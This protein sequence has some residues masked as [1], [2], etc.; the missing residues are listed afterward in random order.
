MNIHYNEIISDPLPLKVIN[1][2]NRQSNR[3]GRYKKGLAP[4]RK[5]RKRLHKKLAKRGFSASEAFVIWSHHIQGYG[6]RNTK[7]DFLL[8]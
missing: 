8:P 3:E 2:L 1:E 7:Y 5:R 4:L 6:T